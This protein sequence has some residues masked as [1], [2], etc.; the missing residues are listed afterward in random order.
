MNKRSRGTLFMIL[1]VIFFASFVVL[2]LITGMWVMAALTLVGATFWSWQLTRRVRENLETQSDAW[3]VKRLGE[4][5]DRNLDDQRNRKG[6]WTSHMIPS[7][8]DWA[9]FEEYANEALQRGATDPVE[10]A[11]YRIQKEAEIK[12]FKEIRGRRYPPRMMASEITAE[13]IHAETIYGTSSGPHHIEYFDVDQ[14][15]NPHW[16]P[17]EFGRVS[18]IT[19]FRQ[20]VWDFALRDGYMHSK[21]STL[22]SSEWDNMSIHK[23]RRIVLEWAEKEY[24]TPLKA[25]VFAA[26]VGD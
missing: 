21:D 12:E 16:E 11:F 22:F 9:K 2:D 20:H 3:Q 18:E 1:S 7:E 25:D 14:H 23:R 8:V 13:T 5:L 6:K 17:A 24:K 15:T 4:W 10:A 19:R 26:I